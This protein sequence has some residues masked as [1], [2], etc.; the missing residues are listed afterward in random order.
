MEAM[1]YMDQKYIYEAVEGKAKAVTYRPWIRWAAAAACLVLVV[2]LC[3]GIWGGSNPQNTEPQLNAQEKEIV[4]PPTRYGKVQ[5][6][7]SLSRAYT[8]HEAVEE[9]QIVARVRIGNWLGENTQSNLVG[10]TYFE[11]EVLETYKGQLSGSF[12]LKQYGST[13]GTYKGFPLFTHGNELIL[14]LNPSED[15]EFGDCY[16]I[17]GTYATVLYVLEDAEGTAYVDAKIENI[18]ASLEEETVNY[19]TDGALKTELS[20][21]VASCD[22][23]L[24]STI[25]MAPEIYA[26]EDI[27]DI[28]KG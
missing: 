19:A 1:E 17:L 18:F 20:V 22:E 4:L 2:G 12:V 27:E 28:L 8:L 13:N 26:L 21:R 14:F 24:S 5:S 3:V 10:R 6:A 23:I 15:T 7:A 11:A 9:A 16:F 25:T